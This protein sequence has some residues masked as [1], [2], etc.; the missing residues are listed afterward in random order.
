MPVGFGVIRIHHRVDLLAVREVVGQR[1][2]HLGE[3]RVLLFGDLLRRQALRREDTDG[4]GG[5]ACAAD[6]GPAIVPVGV[7]VMKEPMSKG[8]VVLIGS[9]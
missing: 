7:A 4:S 5:L 8:A 1:C 9:V 6:E 2:I 3:R